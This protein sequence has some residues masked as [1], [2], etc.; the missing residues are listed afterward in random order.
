MPTRSHQ[1]PADEPDLQR[2]LQIMDCRRVTIIMVYLHSQCLNAS[3]RQ[4]CVCIYV[5][6]FNCI[7]ICAYLPLC[8]KLLGEWGIP[9][10]R[11]WYRR[12]LRVS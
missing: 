1:G 6:M 8:L 7:C 9:A 3:I 11:A 2:R 5:D 4:M 12:T 10:T